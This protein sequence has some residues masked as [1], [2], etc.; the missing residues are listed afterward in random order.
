MRKDK[1]RKLGK[2]E[3]QDDE[4]RI[5][6][7]KEKSKKYSRAWSM[8]ESLLKKNGAENR[9]KGWGPEKAEKCARS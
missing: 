1:Y 4:K 9:V 7:E 3:H 6:K 8:R 5:K 2:V